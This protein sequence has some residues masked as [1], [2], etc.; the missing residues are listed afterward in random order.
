MQPWQKAYYSCRGRGRQLPPTRPNK[1]PKR[2]AAGP[3][4]TG[5]DGVSVVTV[6]RL[7]AHAWATVCLRTRPRLAVFANQLTRLTRLGY[8]KG[9]AGKARYLF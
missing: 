3:L 9:R 4:G 1:L 2:R 8:P 5:F 7:P 6:L